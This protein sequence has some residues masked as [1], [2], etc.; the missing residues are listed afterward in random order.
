MPQKYL[1]KRKA[2]FTVWDLQYKEIGENGYDQNN[3]ICN[4][5][6]ISKNM[7]SL[8]QTLIQIVYTYNLVLNK[9]SVEYTSK[10]TGS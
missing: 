4:N 6:H 10:K 1:R 5:T 8:T 7:L 9:E 2:L 3:L